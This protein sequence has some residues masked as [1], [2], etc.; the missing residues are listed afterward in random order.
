M[1]HF[2]QL[3][4]ETVF[5]VGGETTEVYQHTGGLLLL[6]G[7]DQTD[8]T[9]EKFKTH[10]ISRMKDIPQFRW[11][12][13]EV[14]FGLD[15]P[16]WVEDEEFSF[17]HHIKHIAVPSPGDDQALSELVSYIYSKH[18]NRDRPLWET[19]FIEGV[20][21]GQYAVFQKYHHCMMDGEG[22]TKLGQVVIDATPNAKPAPV[23]DAIRNAKPGVAPTQW[24][25]SINTMKKLS[26]LP[27]NIGSEAIDL[28][29]AKI[30]T[31]KP[32]AKKEKK[33]AKQITAPVASFNGQISADRGFVFGSLPLAEIKAI[34][35]H[36]D[37]T[38]NDTILAIV[39]GS[40]HNLLKRRGELPDESLRTSIAISLR[41]D[42]DDEFSNRVT[43]TTVTL[44]T[45]LTDPVSRLHAIAEDTRKAK[46]KAHSGKN[47]GP[48]EYAQLLPPVAVKAMLTFPS[49]EQVITMSGSNLLVSNVRGSNKPMYLG[50][51]R[52]TA[53]YPISIIGTGMGINITCISYVD[54]VNFG[55]TVDPNLFPDPWEMMD[56]LKEALDEFKKLTDKPP[57]EKSPGTRRK[58]TPK[59]AAKKATARKPATKKPAAKNAG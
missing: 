39:S 44:A 56:A 25:Q 37:V 14:P 31:L 35:N 2:K 46:D 52:E 32:G 59:A 28:L 9:F 33:P 7:S 4:P 48:L 38:I 10:M 41:S 58:S 11:K 13:H 29:K 50:G 21:D 19:W 30:G 6:D 15:L 43:S 36:F 16:Y 34:K 8:Y 51:L 24:E 47:K 18:L 17:D 1:S 20:A 55:I 23:P 5:Y 42:D 27:V 26:S 3:A 45:A 57:K 40:L 53:M 54:N 49:P 12:L 22:A